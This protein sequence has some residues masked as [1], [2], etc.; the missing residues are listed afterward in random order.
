MKNKKMVIVEYRYT[1]DDAIW[2]YLFHNG[3]WHKWKSYRE[4]SI[5]Q[6]MEVLKRKHKDFEFRIKT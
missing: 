4:R 3:E 2:K 6:V 1:K 5:P